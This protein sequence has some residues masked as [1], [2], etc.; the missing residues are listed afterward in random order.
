MENISQVAFTS[1]VPETHELLCS[2]AFGTHKSV[3]KNALNI[4]DA[5]YR[6]THVRIK[7]A[8]TYQFSK[9]QYERPENDCKSMKLSVELDKHNTDGVN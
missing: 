2:R 6:G 9:I 3:P 5:L 4:A 8:M 1:L 7:S